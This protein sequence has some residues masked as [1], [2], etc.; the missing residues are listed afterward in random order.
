MLPP[1][2]SQQADLLR[3]TF[4][5]QTNHNILLLLRSSPS[6]QLLSCSILWTGAVAANVVG[7]VAAG[8]VS[9]WLAA[10]AY[11]PGPSPSPLLLCPS[12]TP[13]LPP[14]AGCRP[15]PLLPHPP[16]G[17]AGGGVSR[18]HLLRLPADVAHQHRQVDGEWHSL[19]KMEQEELECIGQEEELVLKERL[20]SMLFCA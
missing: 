18:Q 8:V 12:C 14:P 2:S 9:S 4:R 20:V 16:H 3:T 6:L 1:V 19:P 13:L 7:V 10:S 15:P 11:P 17:H 5:S